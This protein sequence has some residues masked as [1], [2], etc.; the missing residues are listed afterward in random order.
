MDAATCQWS[1]E[2]PMDGPAIE[3][4]PPRAHQPAAVF[5]FTYTKRISFD[6]RRAIS[7]T[8]TMYPTTVTAISAT[9]TASSQ[10]LGTKPDES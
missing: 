6:R 8:P 5:S 7:T 2:R 3:I 10:P 1:A 4:T 9:D